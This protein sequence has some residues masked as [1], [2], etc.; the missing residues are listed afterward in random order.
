LGYKCKIN[1]QF[2]T[3]NQMKKV[4]SIIAVAVLATTFVACGPSAE[5]KAKMEE[6]EKQIKDSIA[7]TISTQMET[8]APADSTAAPA[9]T[10]TTAPAAEAGHSH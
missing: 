9:T 4:F 2:K 3:S 6:R 1:K 10:E 7:A 5:D 8:T